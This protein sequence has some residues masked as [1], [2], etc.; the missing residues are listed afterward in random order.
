ML[1]TVNEIGEDRTIED[2]EKDYL[3]K[4]GK[5][6]EALNNYISAIDLKILKTESPDNWKYLNKKLA[7][8]HEYFNCLEVYQKPVNDSKKEDF[9]R[10]SK[11]S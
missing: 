10:K 4:V 11:I 2:L 6:E 1:I 9:F 5:L 7:Y 3:D 8:P